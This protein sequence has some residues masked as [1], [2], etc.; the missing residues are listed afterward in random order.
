ATH[1]LD[2]V[3]GSVNPNCSAT[4]IAEEMG[5][6]DMFCTPPAMITSFVP[7]ITAWAAKWM[8]CCEEPHWRAMVV[9]GSSSGRPAASQHVRAMS[10][11]WGP[12][13]SRH[14][15]KTSSTASGSRSLRSTSAWSTWAPRS[16]GWTWARP[17]PRLPTGVRTATTMYASAMD[18]YLDRDDDGRAVAEQ[19][20]VDGQPGGG[21][22][23]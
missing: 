8:A 14:P 23:D 1:P 2:V 9:P 12:M 22:F 15:K 4:V 20:L 7:L 19:A 11:A 21:T 5:I 3:N 10:P 16:A 18:T 13:A 6:I 17:P